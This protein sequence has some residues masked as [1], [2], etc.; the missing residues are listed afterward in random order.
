MLAPGNGVGKRTKGRRITFTLNYLLE[1]VEFTFS[2]AYYDLVCEMYFFTPVRFTD[3]AYHSQVMLIENVLRF[4]C[5][6]F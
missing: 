3:Y 5:G 2:V 1:W 4:S 6:W